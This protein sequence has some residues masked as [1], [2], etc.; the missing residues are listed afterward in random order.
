M[1]ERVE[2]QEKVLS[3]SKSKE[4]RPKTGQ[5]KVEEKPAESINLMNQ[6]P[7]TGIPPRP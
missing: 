2:R 5:S 3:L 1:K 6:R 4:R 7:Q